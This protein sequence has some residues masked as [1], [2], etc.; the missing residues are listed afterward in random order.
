[1]SELISK[2]MIKAGVSAMYAWEPFFVS[3]SPLVLGLIAS[4]VYLAMDAFRELES[5]SPQEIDK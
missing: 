2:E 3:C 5:H 4:E 1:M